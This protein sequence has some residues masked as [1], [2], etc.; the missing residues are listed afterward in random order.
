MS[1]CKEVWDSVGEHEDLD[2]YQELSS[3]R[4]SGRFYGIRRTEWG[5]DD[6]GGPPIGDATSREEVATQERSGY[7]GSTLAASV[8]TSVSSVLPTVLIGTQSV[9]TT[10]VHAGSQVAIPHYALTDGQLVFDHYTILQA[11]KAIPGWY[12]HA[13]TTVPLS[14]IPLYAATFGLAHT[15]DSI[16]SYV[17]NRCTAQAAVSNVLSGLTSGGLVGSV[18]YGA[19]TALGI[20]HAPM[21]STGLCL[22]W[23]VRNYFRHRNSLTDLAVG[24]VANL[25]GL[26]SFITYA[27]PWLSVMSALIVSIVS[28]S[29]ISWLSELWSRRLRKKLR[30]S[31]AQILGVHAKASRIEIESAYRQS[32]RMHHPDKQGDRTLFELISVSKEILLTAEIESDSSFSFMDLVTSISNSFL[33]INQPVKPKHVLE[34]PA[35]FLASP[36]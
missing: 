8:S 20:A 10:I 33:S 35:D 14:C 7:V 11:S 2:E 28:S 25:A 21:I 23:L 19:I 12:P 4:S 26:A 17:N 30:E 9:F 29:A 5:S 24:G 15:L 1:R 18:Y 27:S 36:D 34:L 13:I 3:Y 6:T 22:A 32:A 31:A 16:H